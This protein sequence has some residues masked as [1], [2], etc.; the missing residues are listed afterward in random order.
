LF[1]LNRS[2]I[3]W[4][5]RPAKTVAIVALALALGLAIALP[6]ALA[7]RGPWGRLSAGVLALFAL[8]EGRRA[9]L[10]HEYRATDAPPAE[11]LHPVTTTDLRVRHFSIAVPELGSHQ[12]RVVHVSDLHVNEDLPPDYFQGIHEAIRG[13]APD[14]IV[15]TGDYLSRADRLPALAA[16]LEGLPPTPYGAFAVLGNHDYWVGRSDEIRSTLARAGVRVIGGTCATL[17][18]GDQHVR[19]CGTDAP[20]GPSFEPAEPASNAAATLVL[21]HTPDN[22]YALAE[23]RVTAVFAGHTHGG[24]FRVPVLGALVVPSRYGRRFDRG[25]FAID[26]THLFV[27]AGVGADSPPLRLWCPPELVVVD[28][29]GRAAS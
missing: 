29:V 7:W 6:A 21:S 17:S 8:G 14:L 9:W 27:S 26:S 1:L 15:M 23:Q 5:D 25:H 19:V 24:Q 20:W 13:A 3:Q 10:R 22:V 2:V 28:L 18:V 12:L 4:V 16:W 11:L